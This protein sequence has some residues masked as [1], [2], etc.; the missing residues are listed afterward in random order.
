MFVGNFTK[1]KDR[2]S[3]LEIPVWRL[4][5]SK[6]RLQSDSDLSVDGVFCMISDKLIENLRG[7]L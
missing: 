3:I 4:S 1:Y 6:I 7:E 2:V 5:Y